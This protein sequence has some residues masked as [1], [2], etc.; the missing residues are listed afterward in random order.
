MLHCGFTAL[1]MCKILFDFIQHKLLKTA[2]ET[3]RV[4]LGRKRSNVFCSGRF[5]INYL[6]TGI[7]VIDRTQKLNVQ[8]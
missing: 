8:V 3:R 2:S 6:I 7:L 1:P 4:V 5:I